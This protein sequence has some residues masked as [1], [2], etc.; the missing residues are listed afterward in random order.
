MVGC[1]QFGPPINGQKTATKISPVERML[2]LNRMVMRDEEPRN[3]ESQAIGLC[4]KW[5]RNNTDIQ[6][7][8]SFSDGKEGNC[9]YIYQATNWKYLG[10]LLSDSFY[11]L[12]GKYVHNVSV[13]H[14]Y[15]E[16]HMYRHTHTTNEILCMHHNDVAKV[17]SKQHIYV[18]PL[19]RNVGFLLEE[20]PY[21]K[22]DVEVEILQRTFIKRNGIV[23][24]EYEKVLYV[25]SLPVGAF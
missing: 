1:L 22:K 2:E 6:Y 24:D 4:M 25:D 14:K 15:K 9:G 23:L 13:W 5:M 12:D 3:S 10:F 7:I 8:L 11:E 20:K 16:K 19:Y 18:F 17:T 21:P